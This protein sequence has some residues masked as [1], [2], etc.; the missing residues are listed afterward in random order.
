MR[1]GEKRFGRTPC[2][3]KV[4]IGSSLIKKQKIDFE[5]ALPDGRTM[6]ETVNLKTSDLQMHN[7]FA[8]NI[9][10]PFWGSGGILFCAGLGVFGDNDDMDT[11]DESAE[12]D[13]GGSWKAIGYGLALI[14]VG[15]YVF[16]ILGG[17]WEGADIYDIHSNFEPKSL[18]IER[19]V[20][21]K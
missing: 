3:V 1:V 15:A 6:T 4:P 17:D 5:F 10:L 12:D 11:F 21:D 9:S 19:P 20:E 13:D 2:Q 14:G 16:T 18:D 7:D 8:R